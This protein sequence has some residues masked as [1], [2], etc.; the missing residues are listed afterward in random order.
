MSTK[1]IEEMLVELRDQYKHTADPDKRAIIAARGRALKNALECLRKKLE[2]KEEV[3]EA[4]QQVFYN[5]E[6]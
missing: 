4:V 1:Q 3:K 2:T 6:K 5:D